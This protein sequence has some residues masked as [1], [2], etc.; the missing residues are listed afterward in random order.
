MVVLVVCLLLGATPAA[1]AGESRQFVPTPGVGKTGSGSPSDDP[2]AAQRGTIHVTIA[3]VPERTSVGELSKVPGMGVGIMSAGIGNVPAAQTYLD[4]G[5]GARVPGSLYDRPLP[6]LTLRGSEGRGLRVPESQWRDVRRRAAS[7]PADIV[8]GLLGATLAR[9]DVAVIHAVESPAITALPL[10]NEQGRMAAPRCRHPGCPN[11]T[12]ASADLTGVRR[13]AAGL[14]AEDL[15]IAMGRPPP[16]ANRGLAIGIAGRGFDG[17]LTSD[18]TRMRGLVLSTDLA[19]TILDR[20]G[21]AAPGDMTGEPIGTDGAV[22]APYVRDLSDRLAAVG[23]R[24]A[25]VVGVSVLGWLVLAALAGL[26]FRR[27][28]LQVALTIL[29]TTLALVPAVLLLCA[30]LEPSEL[31]ERLIVGIGCPALAA[32]VLRMAPGLRGLAIAAAVS[33]VAYGAD[34]VAGSHLT[35]LSLIGPNPIAGTRFYGIGNELEATIAALVPI[36]IGAALAG[37][38]PHSS[39]RTAALAFAVT[40]LAAVAVFAPG[41][42][43]ADVG[44]AIGISIG[45]AVAIGVCLG[46]RRWR[47]LW[48][49][50]APVAA[51]AALLAADLV[52]GGDAHLTRSVLN[53][54]GLGDLGQVLQRR[55]ELSAHSFGRYSGS[56]IFWIIVALIVAGLLGWRSVRGWFGEREAL[57]AGFVGAIAATLAGTLANDS[58]ALLLMIGA[59]LCAATAAV[60]WATY[61]RRRP[62]GLWSPA[63]P[64]T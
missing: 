19:P 1:S 33:V 45:T 5:Q 57:W 31:A 62:P 64:L 11:V 16:P 51:V 8:P 15:L 4:M 20:F 42:F 54:G 46:A 53:A 3:V 21:I 7:A 18:S 14:R 58:G 2:G 36:A 39:S 43:G 61:E 17:T 24:R 13:L 63:G 41:R 12:V 28:G 10:V 55:A 52:S 22:D 26:A 6:R 60:A 48:V 47:W 23:P 35:E 38:T 40:G 37:W 34:V 49:I 25:P 30:A 59:V 27:A 9:A 29:A 44:A 50:V 56:A 32:L